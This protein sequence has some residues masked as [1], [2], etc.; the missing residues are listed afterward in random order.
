MKTIK[1]TESKY[2][3]LLAFIKNNNKKNIDNQILIQNVVEYDADCYSIIESKNNGD[4]VHML[5]PSFCLL[6]SKNNRFGH[7]LR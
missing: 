7:K 3:A 4:N 6:L 1:M 5:D 2:N